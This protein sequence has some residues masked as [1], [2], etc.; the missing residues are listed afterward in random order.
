M[1]KILRIKHIQI[2]LPENN[3]NKMITFN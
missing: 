1:N 3:K 2:R